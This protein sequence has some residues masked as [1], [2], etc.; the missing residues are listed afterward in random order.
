M[1]SKSIIAL[2][3][4]ACVMATG[5]NAASVPEADSTEALTRTE[6][7]PE[8]TN[9]A[10]NEVENQE[11]ESDSNMTDAS[12]Y[13]SSIENSNIDAAVYLDYSAGIEAGVYKWIL[14]EDG[15]YYILAALDEQ[16]EPIEAEQKAI[17][18]GANNQESIDLAGEKKSGE[19]QKGSDSKMTAD[20]SGGGQ[21]QGEGMPGGMMA[22]MNQ[23]TVYQGVYINS[24]ITNTEYQTMD[25]YVPKDYMETDSDGNVTGIN[26]E[27]KI[28][29]YTADTAPVV[30]LNEMG[31]WRSSSPKAPDTS[32][33]NE[34][35]IYVSAGGRS[36]D[37]VDENGNITGKSPTQMVDLKSGLIELR[38]NTDVIPGDMTKII[39][40]GTS[41]GGQMSS[42]LGASGN[43]AVYYPYMYEAGVLGVT[44][45]A[46]GNYSSVFDDSVYAAQLY[47]PI[48]DL[49]NADIAYAWW[50]VNLA[51]KGGVYNGSITD[52]EKRLQELEAEAFVEYI[53]GLNLRD[54]EG[55]ALTLTGLREGT[56]YDAILQNISDALN[57]AVAN[58]DIDPDEAY[59]NY[60]NW[61]EKTEDGTWKVT[62]L[63]GFM[64]GTGLVSKRNKAIPGFD[65]MDKSAEGDAFGTDTDQ[66]VHFSKSVAQILSDNYEELSALKGFDQEAV[67]DYIE[68]AL[69]SDESALI[70]E[71]TNLLNA[72]EILLANNGLNAASFAHYWRDR[73]GTADQHTS[74]SVGYNILLAAQLRGATVDYHLVWDMQHGNNEGTST[75]T[76]IDWINEI[77]S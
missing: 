73:S 75:G 69:N 52:F 62:D 38:A 3:M 63:D 29:S 16:G 9:P 22:M 32:F 11:S 4:T 76:M 59:K 5:C 23:G 40:T 45:N 55:N 19:E 20:K 35:M 39:S 17:N 68:Q 72:T 18:V 24:N 77:C 15:N 34:G 8:D 27:A 41:G 28:G 46:D 43:M 12:E 42:I 70:E 53:N 10:D 57:A 65:T 25:I 48:A 71:Q 33:L 21:K 7:A 2:S 13:V 14:S 30:Y 36:R 74:F 66:A 51:D 54:S 49:E 1:K 64:I 31:G 44:K 50:W 56:Y 26:H 37:A 58:G 67:D 60:S 61:L 6:M 47:C